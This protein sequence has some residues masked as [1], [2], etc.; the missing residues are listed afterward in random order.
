M[1]EGARD[2]AKAM[3]LA[4]AA[5]SAHKPTDTDF[6]GA[7]TKLR[8]AKCDLVLMGTIVRDTIIAYSTARKLGWDAT[9]VGSV[10]TY[11]GAVASAAGGITD[12]Y[13]AMTSQPVVYSDEAS[14]R[15]KEF[16]EAYRARYKQDA[17]GLE[18]GAYVIADIFVEALRRA[19]KDLTMDSL[20]KA[21]ESIDSYA[22]PFADGTISFS[23][24]KHLGFD[25]VFLA[26]VEG[27]RWKTLEKG[28]K[29]K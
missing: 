21:L 11:G 27:G 7:I 28:L 19:G 26:V 23:A 2:Q 10:A 24:T 17:S 6:T 25:Q 16:M 5:E 15:A 3:K 9:F 8:E 4:L 18:Q 14:G 29:Y 20:V 12:G 1:L 13:F 22:N